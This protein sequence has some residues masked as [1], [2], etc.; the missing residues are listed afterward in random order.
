MSYLDKLETGVRHFLDEMRG[1]WA[2]FPP[3]DS[4]DFPDQ[5]EVAIKARARWRQGGP[6]MARTIDRVFDPGT[7]EL[8]IRVYLPERITQSAPALVYLHGGGFTLFSIETHDRLMREYAA[9][10]GFAVIGVDYPLSPEH[11]YPVALDRIEALMLWLGEHGAELGVDGNWLAIGG[12]SAGAN[13]AF[14]ATMRL[15]QR[16]AAPVRAILANYG[17]FSTDISDEAEAQFG[18]AGT[19]MDRA[20]VLQYAANYITHDDEARDPFAFPLSADLSGFPP[21][22][23]IVPDSDILTEQSIAMDQRLRAARVEVDCRTYA[24]ATHSFLEAMSVSEIARR[25]IVDGATF[26]RTKLAA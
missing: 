24:G 6:E 8:G 3:F 19:I 17:F 16:G 4:L 13:L 10:G 23:L 26:V 18:G 15:R 12:D 25:A 2:K 1:E 22:M 5:R 11:K 14:T 20:E 7:G 21:V 9:A